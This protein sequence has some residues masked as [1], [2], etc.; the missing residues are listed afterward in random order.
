MLNTN[1]ID[2]EK[3]RP[4]KN[5]LE[6][7]WG[8]EKDEERAKHYLELAAMEG[9]V[10]ARHNLGFYEYIAG[11]YERAFKH[12]MIAVR[13]GD[14]DSNKEIQRKYMGGHVT[15]DQYANA[16]QSQQAYLNEIKSDQRDKA[17]ALGDDYRYH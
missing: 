3:R 14:T 15:K 1:I 11:N 17:A 6:C 2:G 12:Y 16:L 13:G 7:D 10:L 9:M 5:L 4:I 8:V